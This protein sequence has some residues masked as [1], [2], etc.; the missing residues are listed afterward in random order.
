MDTLRP[1]EDQLFSNFLEDP[2]LLRLLYDINPTLVFVKDRQGRFV[3]ANRALAD[4]YGT[5]VEGLVGKTDA[6]FNPEIDEI[7]HFLADDLKVMD[8][9]EELFIAS[10][11]VTDEDGSTVWLQ[12]IKRPLVDKKGN[13]NH[14][15]GVCV[16]ITA[17]IKA[18]ARERDLRDRLSRSERMESLGVMAGGIAHDLNNILG[19]LVGYPDLLLD[20]LEQ[21][22]EACELV[23]DMRSSSLRAAAVIQD[24]LTLARRGTFEAEAISVNDAVEEFLRSATHRELAADYALVRTIVDLGAGL[25]LIMGSHNHFY[26]VTMN[27]V[28]NAYEAMPEGGTL[29]VATGEETLGDDLVVAFGEI[30]PGRY[31]YLDVRDTGEGIAED[32][33]KRIFEPFYSTKS[34]NGRGTGLGLAVVFGILHDMNG[35]VQLS[36]EPGAGTAF[37]LRFPAVGEDAGSGRRAI[38]EQVRGEGHLLVVDDLLSQRHLAER[39]LG[40]LGYTVV[41]AASGDE[42]VRMLRNGTRFDLAVIDMIMPGVDG[43]DTF[44][45]IHAEVPGL[46]CLIASGYAEGSRISAA[47]S[48]GAAGFVKKPFTQAVMGRGIKDAIGSRA[49]SQ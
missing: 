31:V 29:S 45:A 33:R 27:L 19:P 3:F 17:R 8:T 2:E 42:A 46:P 20:M 4:V 30:G 23:Q 18:E 41:T 36:T 38:T 35:S 6:D 14:L 13:C 37:R 40:A 44:R 10:E 9:Q 25:P 11:K 26:Q 15:L 21:D 49:E 12:T 22:S 43:L 34:Q 1:N 16:D 48:E 24:L 39:M 28:R 32:E 47:L 7:E 5:T